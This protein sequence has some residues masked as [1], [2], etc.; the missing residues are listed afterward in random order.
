MTGRVQGVWYRDS[1]QQEAK[2]LGVTG[3]ARN[4]ENGR[5]EV[6]IEGEA[7]DVAALER[8]CAQGPP[9]AVV[10]GVDG[11]DEPVEGLVAFRVR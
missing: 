3:W 6:V 1:C 5:V 10:T 4:L 11:H 9:R 2:R 7:T 8:W